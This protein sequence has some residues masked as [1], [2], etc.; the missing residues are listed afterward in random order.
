MRR[1]D[2]GNETCG[3]VCVPGLASAGNNQHLVAFALGVAVIPALGDDVHFFPGV[4][5]DVI[6]E[7]RVGWDVPIQ[8]VRIAKSV[9]EDFSP[10][11][12][13]ENK[14]VRVGPGAWDAIAAVL[15]ALVVRAQRQVRSD[16][17]NFALQRA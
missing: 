1:S 2:S 5:A 7:Q 14:W 11:S 10:R 16:A 17:Q 8:A 13:N 4:Q 12:G 6:C 15:A 9:R 3:V